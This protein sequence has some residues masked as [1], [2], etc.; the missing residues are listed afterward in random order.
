MYSTKYIAFV[1]LDEVILP[2]HRSTFTWSQLIFELVGNNNI[3]FCAFVFK[4]LMFNIDWPDEGNSTDYDNYKLYNIISLLK[5]KREPK[6]YRF[7]SRS[8][9]IVDPK[10][11]N[12]MTVHR[13]EECIKN[14]T[15]FYVPHTTA[16]LHHYRNWND[17]NKYKWLIDKTALKYS[18]FLLNQIIQNE[19]YIKV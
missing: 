15:S 19:K 9:V 3:N 14:Y 6:P 13:V 12:V 2:K 5:T 18:P 10:H 16:A 17:K 8:K 4:C 11:V 7:N 1:D